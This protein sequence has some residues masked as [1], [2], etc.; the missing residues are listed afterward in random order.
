MDNTLMPLLKKTQNI[1]L[2][3]VRRLYDV[4]A[5]SSIEL[6]VVPQRAPSSLIS[7]F[8]GTDT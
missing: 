6:D 2:M 4:V 1:E 8:A 3:F 5:C 7:L